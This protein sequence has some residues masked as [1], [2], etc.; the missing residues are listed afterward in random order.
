MCSYRQLFFSSHM[1]ASLLTR[2]CGA[3]RMVPSIW[4]LDSDA[5]VSPVQLGSF[6]L[7]ADVPGRGELML[8]DV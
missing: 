3:R 8:R 2:P 6:R 1:L 5:D 4:L 7:E